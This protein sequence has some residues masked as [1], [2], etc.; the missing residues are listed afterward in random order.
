VMSVR[1]VPPLSRAPEDNEPAARL[2]RSCNRDA[3]R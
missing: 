2:K 3:G 1:M